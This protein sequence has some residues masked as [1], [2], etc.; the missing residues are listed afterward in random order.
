MK[1]RYSTHPDDAARLGSADLR[2]RFVVDD[3]FVHGEVRLTLAHDD[4]IVVGGAVPDGSALRLEP[5]AELRTTTFCERRELAV[6]NLG[7]G[8]GTVTVDGAAHTLGHHDVL[9][10]GVGT[11]DVVLGGDP[12][13]GDVR[14]YLVSTPASARHPVRLVR[15]DEAESLRLGDATAANERV[16]RRYVHAGGAPSD[17]LVLGIT[18]LLPGSVWNT[19]PPHLHDRRT[20]VYLYTGLGPDARVLHLCGRPDELR[21]LVM[22]DGEAV[23]S[24]PWSVHAGAGTGSY[25][26]VWAMSGENQAFDDMD[27]V[28]LGDLR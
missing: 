15:A 10:A 8:M 20:E 3:L 12:S 4:R 22:A 27:A 13:G 25:S 7:D 6:V 17:R 23:I 24:P 9:Y 18:T 28:A 26:F 11:D 1:V 19:M 16:L 21:T 2:A 14:Y 5:P